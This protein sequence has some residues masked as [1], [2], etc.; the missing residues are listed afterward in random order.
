MTRVFFFIRTFVLQLII[1]TKPIHCVMTALLKVVRNACLCVPNFN[2]GPG[3]PVMLPNFIC[4]C[5]YNL[6]RAIQLKPLFDTLYLMVFYDMKNHCHR[7]WRESYVFSKL[8]A[9]ICEISFV[10]LDYVYF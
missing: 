5:L 6:I 1:L 8:I 10:R 2:I 9:I 4:A 3:L 7:S